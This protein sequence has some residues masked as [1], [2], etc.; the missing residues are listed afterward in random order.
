MISGIVFKRSD[1]IL[2]F[3]R[4]FNNSSSVLWA[5]LMSLTTTT[6]PVNRR[7]IMFDSNS[8]SGTFQKSRNKK[9]VAPGSS[10]APPGGDCLNRH[11]AILGQHFLGTSCRWRGERS[12]WG[13]SVYRYTL[14]DI[15]NLWKKVSLVREFSSSKTHCSFPLWMSFLL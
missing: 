11:W 4:S 7:Q 5:C 14:P 13:R 3:K 10:V 1:N 12:A 15:F 2:V 9:D 8:P 6:V